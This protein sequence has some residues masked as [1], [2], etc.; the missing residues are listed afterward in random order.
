MLTRAEIRRSPGRFAAITAALALI[1]FL[2]L[3]LS[4]LADGLFYGATGAMRTTTANAW[5]FNGETPGSLI[6]SQLPM[7]DAEKF[8]AVPGVEA[9]SAVGLL[10]AAGS[11]P[12]GL[13]DLAVFGVGFGGGFGGGPGGA[14]L[15]RELAAGRLPAPGEDGTAAVDEKLGAV[16]VTIGSEITVGGV[17]VKVV[18]LTIDSTYQ[19]QPSVWTTIPTWERMRSSVRPETRGLVG[20]VNAVALTLAGGADP[21]DVAGQV[22]GTTVL[23]AEEAALAIPGVTQQKSSLSAII[24]AALLVAVLV[25]A[26]FFALL[27]LEKRELFAALK[28]IGTS[29]GRLAVGVVTQA[30]IASVAGVVVGSVVARLLGNLLP[31]EIPALFRT[32]TLIEVAVFVVVAGVAGALLSLRRI[33]RIDPAT[34]LG[35]AN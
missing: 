13:V 29:T 22:P 2:V 28:A 1:T 9:A 15:P 3:M 26:L 25:V 21:V 10:L 24:Y 20:Q 12:E 34:A 32:D 35:G 5:A 23:T 30:F 14:G 8:R 33:S 6:R 31:A 7:A 16:G 4:A 19:L 27:V 11:G 17:A 18:G